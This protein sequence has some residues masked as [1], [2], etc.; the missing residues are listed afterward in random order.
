M[1]LKIKNENDLNNLL[2][3]NNKL[4]KIEIIVELLQQYND[5]EIYDD[6]KNEIILYNIDEF[7]IDEIIDEKFNYE[8]IKIDPL[9]DEI[10]IKI[11]NDEFVE[12]NEIENF[13]ELLK[14]YH[15]NILINDIVLNVIE[16][17]ELFNQ[18][19]MNLYYDY[20]HKFHYLTS[21]FYKF[22]LNNNDDDIILLNKFKKIFDDEFIVDVELYE[23]IYELYDDVELYENYDVELFDENNIIINHD[24]KT[25][26]N[27]NDDELYNLIGSTINKYLFIDNNVKILH[28]EIIELLNIISYEFLIVEFHDE[29]YKINLTYNYDYKISGMKKIK[30]FID[31][32]DD[33]N[34]IFEFNDLYELFDDEIHDVELI[35]YD[36]VI[37]LFDVDDVIE[38]I[39]ENVEID[40]NY[41]NYENY[42]ELNK[43]FYRIFKQYHLNI[44]EKIYDNIRKIKTL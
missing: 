43:L 23:N 1:N 24:L 19:G 21:N 31:E 16:F 14:Y 12:K 18:I 5:V 34:E 6:E 3:C 37:E 39:V 33:I 30:K 22:K 38:F 27:I 17:D 8:I 36:D 29:L 25:I 32:I 28:D 41:Y 15:E 10:I 13:Q 9:Y 20:I 4:N 26:R 11:D 44:N 2:S 42:V 35:Q 40:Y 7:D